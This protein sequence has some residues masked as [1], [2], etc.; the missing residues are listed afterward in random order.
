MAGSSLMADRVGAALG[1][2]CRSARAPPAHALRNGL[3][4]SDPQ[5]AD[6]QRDQ[7]GELRG[8]RSRS[9]RSQ[10]SSAGCKSHAAARSADTPPPRSDTGRRKRRRDGIV[11]K[12]PSSTR[13]SPTNRWCPAA[14]G[15][16]RHDCEIAANSGTTRAI[17]PYVLDQPAVAGARRSC[18]PGRTA[19]GRIP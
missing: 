7:H 11:R 14:R 9:S 17:P 6:D 4:R 2:I 5:N 12:N 15:R 13:N 16:E 8:V 19:A 3:D 18:R 1:F 10:D